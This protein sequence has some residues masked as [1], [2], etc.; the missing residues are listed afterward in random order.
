MPKFS[1]KCGKE[2]DRTDWGGGRNPKNWGVETNMIGPNGKPVHGPN[3]VVLK[4][5]VRMCDGQF[6]DGSAQSLYYPEG[7][8]LAGVFKG[9]GVILEERR[10][11]RATK[12]RAECPKFQCERGVFQ[13]CCWRMLYNEPDFVGVKSLLEIACEA[14]GYCTIFFPKFHCELN[15][16]E[17]CW[18]YSKR[19]YC[20]YPP[21]S[22]E[23]NLEHNVLDSLNTIL[24]VVI[25]WCVS[26]LSSITCLILIYS[27]IGSLLEH[28]ILWTHI[29]KG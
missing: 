18:G 3:G 15:F 16:I 9:I 24:I 13:C 22:K 12:I 1:P 10:F 5:K 21:S 27:T 11:D 2:W 17:Q 29:E 19:I 20:Q 26:K 28:S 23:S 14:R 7:H 6:A 8:G 4:Q 25:C